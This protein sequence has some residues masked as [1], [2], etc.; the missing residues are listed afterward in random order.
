MSFLTRLLYAAGF[1]PPIPEPDGQGG[2]SDVTPVLVP[3]DDQ[4]ALWSNDGW[5]RWADKSLIHPG[6]IGGKIKPWAAVIHTT[7]M[8]PDRF[9]AL[10]KRWKKVPGAGAGAHFLLGRNEEEGLHQLVPTNRNANHAGGRT[11]GNFHVD[12]KTYS[13]NNC[14]IGIEVMNA[15]R[16]HWVGGKWRTLD[17]GVPFGTAIPEE[18]VVHEGRRSYHDTTEYQ[19]STLVTLLGDLARHLKDRVPGV[20]GWT[21]STSLID[22]KHYIRPEWAPYLTYLGLPVVGHVTLTPDRKADPHLPLSGYLTSALS[23]S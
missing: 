2:A 6:R 15:G 13:P 23:Q 16:V 17:K 8:H 5:Y 14:S 10:V 7:D 19:K 1:H 20:G 18:D 12:G 3:D 11:H 4:I 9:F 21:C 22:G